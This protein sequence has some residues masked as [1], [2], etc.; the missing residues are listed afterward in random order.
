ME[1][2]SKRPHASDAGWRSFPPVDP[3]VVSPVGMGRPAM[4]EKRGAHGSGVLSVAFIF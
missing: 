4:E 3:V 2:N 1:W